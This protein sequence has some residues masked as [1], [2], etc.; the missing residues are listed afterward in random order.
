MIFPEPSDLSIIGSFVSITTQ[1]MEIS[2]WSLW[3][4]ADIGY[5]ISGD[6]W[7]EDRVL[8]VDLANKW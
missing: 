1:A 2:E 8:L 5:E 6:A 7:H 4:Q 3:F